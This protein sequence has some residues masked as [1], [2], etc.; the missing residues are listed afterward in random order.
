MRNFRQ[1]L[2]S[3]LSFVDRQRVT[4]PEWARNRQSLTVGS[5]R[6]LTVP[7]AE[8]VRDLLIKKAIDNAD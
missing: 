7:G 1:G 5:A 4:I 3:L 8:H 6:L 2:A